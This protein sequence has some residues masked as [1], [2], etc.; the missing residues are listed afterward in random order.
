MT[1]LID[2]GKAAYALGVESMDK[3]HEEFVAIVNRI[4]LADKDDFATLFN[5]LVTHTEQH[6]LAENKLMALTSF[7]AIREHYSEH[8]RVLS[9]LKAI[10]Y[11]VQKG[12][13]TMAR[14]YISEHIPDWFDL[15]I[16]TMDA[17]L[18]RHIILQQENQDT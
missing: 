1:N 6:F 5:D 9:D 17:A 2:K 12:K 7:P 3:T 4:A 15:H 18:S 14:A 10:V 13:F 11:Q 8:T 16:L